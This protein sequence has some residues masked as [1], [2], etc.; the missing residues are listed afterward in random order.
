MLILSVDTALTG[1]S[2]CLLQD[3]KIIAYE[4]DQRPSKQAEMLIPMIDEMLKSKKI[5]YSDIDLF[6]SSIG[7]GSFTGLR[8]GI[9]AVKGFS[10]VTGKPACGVTTLQALALKG[11]GNG[12]VT[13]AINAGR[14]QFYAQNFDAEL[15]P[16]SEAKLVN[17]EDLGEFTPDNTTIITNAYELL[18]EHYNG[19]VLEGDHCPTAREVAILA[20]KDQSLPAEPLYIRAPDAK[21]STK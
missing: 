14:N 16:I 2:A 6:S 15:N 7:P 12:N 9:T 5:S 21:K 10:L 11:G 4:A 20:A 3:G 19:A 13:A 17:Y 8:I 1:C 18:K